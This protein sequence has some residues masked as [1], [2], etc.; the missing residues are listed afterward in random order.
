MNEINPI[1]NENIKYDLDYIK[2]NIDLKE[3]IK[4]LK[5]DLLWNSQS[6]LIV[7][8]YAIRCCLNDKN[9]D[10]NIINYKKK[11]NNDPDALEQFLVLNLY[12]CETEHFGKTDSLSS[13]TIKM[14]KTFLETSKNFWKE[15][16][17]LQ[18]RGDLLERISSEFKK[19]MHREYVGEQGKNVVDSHS[20]YQ[21]T[22]NQSTEYFYLTKTGDYNLVVKFCGKLNEKEF[23]NEIV[24]FK[25][26]RGY[27]G[28][29]NL[30]INN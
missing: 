21:L 11:Y 28:K 22:I 14:P 20:F 2:K 17:I 25:S 30:I 7:I 12:N 27:N 8:D 15:I 24:Q 26:A 18:D 6:E 5:S 1:I 29:E 4:K 23:I 10:P 9:N 13:E 16:E 19:I 3:F